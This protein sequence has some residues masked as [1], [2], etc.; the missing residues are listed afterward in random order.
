[1]SFCKIWIVKNAEST[2]DTHKS[3]KLIPDS[4]SLPWLTVDSKHQRLEATEKSNLSGSVI[5]V[6]LTDLLSILFGFNCFAFEELKHFYLFGQIQTSKQEVSCIVIFP[7][8]VSVL[9]NNCATTTSL[10]VRMA[11]YKCSIYHLYLNHLE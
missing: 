6:R 4:F 8:M 11:S 3:G 9:N 1:M 5:T 10:C 2:H 7:P